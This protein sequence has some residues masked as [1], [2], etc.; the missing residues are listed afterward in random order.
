VVVAHLPGRHATAWH[1][2][3]DAADLL[4]GGASGGD[5][6]GLHLY[7]EHPELQ[8]GP[9]AILAA[10][11][12]TALGRAA[13]PAAMVAASIL[14]LLALALVLGA[15]DRLR[16]GSV[17]S[18][19]APVLLVAGAVAVVTWGDIAVRT[20]HLDDALA[21]LAVSAALRWCA[22]G[23][24]GRAVVVALA[25]AAAV[26]P[27]A[28]VFAPLAAVAAGHRRWD[29]VAIVG[30]AVG[31]TWA[32]F[33]LAEPSTLDAGRY[34][35]T[36][37]PTSVLRALGVDD[38]STP[39]WV[40]PAQLV[41]GL[42]VVALVVAARRWPAALLAGVAWRLLLEPGAHRYYTAGVVL[43]LLVVELVRDASGLPWR[44]VLA[45]V[46]L[47]LTALPGAPERAA[48]VLRLVCVLAL[49]VTAA[50]TPPVSGASSTSRTRPVRR[51]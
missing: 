18:A 17:A 30:V 12:F 51:C 15:V 26:K 37:D 7:A 27:W 14:G 31:A 36:N 9:L 34:R 48:G 10:A 13:E 11:P 41:G 3:E 8:F 6:G 42:A 40:R 46:V 43:G 32:P 38:P 45:A 24:P 23:D 16:P 19:P 35:I 4:F 29:R 50:A 20:A 28:I 44:T 22:G 2:F 5:P 33:V 21:L 47:E 25:V 49:L 1:F 39:L